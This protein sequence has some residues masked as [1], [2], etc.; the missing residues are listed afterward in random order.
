M[1]RPPC[2][3]LQAGCNDGLAP[4]CI[5]SHYAVRTSALKSIGGLGPELAEDHS[6]TLLMNAGGWRGAFAFDAIAHG[7]GAYGFYDAITQEFQWARSLMA[8]FY[9][10]T[11]KCLGNLSPRLKLQFLSQLWY[12]LT[13]LAML[14]SYVLPVMAVASNTPLINVDYLDFVLHF[15][16][17]AT[18]CLAIVLWVRAVDG[19]DLPSR[20]F[21]PGRWFY[22][23][24]SGGRGFSWDAWMLLSLLSE[25]R[26]LLISVSPQ[27]ADTGHCLTGHLFLLLSVQ[28][29]RSC[30]SQS[31]RIY[32]WLLF[33]A[34][35]QLHCVSRCYH[36][37][38][39]PAYC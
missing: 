8:I 15:L 10:L 39:C 16:P 23:N 24:L 38:Y 37:G 5:G 25:T 1:Q 7:Y 12:P 35:L 22:S 34:S 21:L 2:G 28:F 11:P 33:P 20:M 29:L 17:T 13:G 27:R 32:S 26:L 36:D 4:M 31:W 19:P 9:E 3:A 6:T 18:S 30:L 14:A